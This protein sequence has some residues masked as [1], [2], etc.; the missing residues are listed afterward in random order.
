MYLQE[1]ERVETTIQHA[2]YMGENKRMEKGLFTRQCVGKINIS[3]FRPIKTFI[4]NVFPEANQLLLLVGDTLYLFYLITIIICSDNFYQS[5]EF[6]K[7]GLLVLG[8]LILK[9]LTNVFCL[10]FYLNF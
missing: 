8:R 5:G 9:V 6:M 7:Y 4:I 3:C 10:Q 2:L 1:N